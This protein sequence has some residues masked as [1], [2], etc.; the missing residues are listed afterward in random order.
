V[1][2][3]TFVP[4]DLQHL[5]LLSLCIEIL[6]LPQSYD[7]CV[8]NADDPQLP[9]DDD[10]VRG[11]DPPNLLAV[12]GIDDRQQQPRDD[13]VKP[14]MKDLRVWVLL[15]VGV[16][17]S[18]LYRHADLQSREADLQSQKEDLQSQK[19][20]L[21]SREA[22]LKAQKVDLQ[23]QKK[24]L[25]SR[26][27]DLKAQKVDLLFRKA[28][29]QFQKAV[30][31]SQKAALQSQKADLQ[32]WKEGLQSWAENLQ[33]RE[34]DVQWREDDEKL[35]FLRSLVLDDGPQALRKLLPSSHEANEMV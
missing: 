29:L 13:G 32:S 33:N 3:C 6:S 11:I 35:P 4:S 14:T 8:V 2:S 27:A 9:R 5:T 1:N 25:Q 15:I 24:D 16:V 21:Q 31:Q 20:D 17:V 22:D 23:S 10:I 26:E 28:A 18:V 30:L 12:V 7:Q 19:K 34:E